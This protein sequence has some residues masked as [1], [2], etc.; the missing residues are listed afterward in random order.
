M[1]SLWSEISKAIHMFK[2]KTLKE[3]VSLA[4]MKDEQLQRQRRIS[5]PPLPTRTI[6][7]TNTNKSFTAQIGHHELEVL[8]DSGSM[9]NFLGANMC[10]MVAISNVREDLNTYGLSFEKALEAYA[11]I[12]KEPKQLSPVHEVDHCIPS[13]TILSC[14]CKTLLVGPFSKDEIEKQVQ[15]MLKLGLIKPSTKIWNLAFCINYRA[16][17]VMTIKDRFP[18]PTIDDML[19]ELYRATYF[20]ELDLRAW[21]HQG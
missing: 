15:D 4:C 9:H 17:N 19:D 10:L 14:Q 21:Y 7:S 6:G 2:P 20:T 8:I 13:K 12:F 18:I 1:G 5:R 16:L 3:V 11:Y